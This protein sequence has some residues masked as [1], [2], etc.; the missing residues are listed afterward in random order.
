M[1][2]SKEKIFLFVL[3]FLSL[4]LG[5]NSEMKKHEM[6]GLI[7]LVARDYELCVGGGARM[8]CD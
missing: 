7:F 3:L 5:K 2:T 6:D 4:R 1:G 8:R